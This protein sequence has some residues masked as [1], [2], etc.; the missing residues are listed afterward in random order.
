MKLAPNLTYLQWMMN[1]KRMLLKV[2]KKEMVYL[3]MIIINIKEWFLQLSLH[4][5]QTLNLQLSQ[6]V[7]ELE[8]IMILME[9][10]IEKR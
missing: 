7:K 8:R 2:P 5:S 3:K 4:L 1:L 9:R 10:L 6:Q